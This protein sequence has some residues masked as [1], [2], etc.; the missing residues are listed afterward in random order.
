MVPG[1]SIPIASSGLMPSNGAFGAYAEFTDRSFRFVEAEWTSS[2]PSVMTV[3][4]ATLRALARGTGTITATTAGHTASETVT[5]NPGIPGTWAGSFVV[6][7]CVAGSGTIDQLI[8]SAVPGREP[9]QW[10][11]GASRPASFVITQSGTALTAPAAFGDMRGTLTG[12]DRGSNVLTFSGEL[13]ADR[14][15]IKLTHWDSR[16]SIDLMEGFVS[17]E[18]RVD[19]AASYALVSGHFAN[20]TRR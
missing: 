2:D 3:A 9:G 17:F 12:T 4:N 13:R 1:G 7:R 6:D 5:V 15:T 8:C 10:P 18:V 20:V 11:A 16:V 14:T 19:G